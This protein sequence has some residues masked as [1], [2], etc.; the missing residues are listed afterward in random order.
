MK[1]SNLK[2]TA[3]RKGLAFMLILTLAG[4]AAGFYYGLQQIRT[5][6]V[7]V[8]NKVADAEASGAQIEQLRQLQQTLQQSDALIA[9]ADSIFATDASYQT[10]AITDLERYASVAGIDIA[11]TE[12]PT[13]AP[14]T[15][16]ARTV[17]VS[18]AQPLS[19]ERLLRFLEL[20]E[21]NLPKMQPT[22]ITV[23]RPDQPDGDAVV[24]SDI[25]I[26]ISTRQQ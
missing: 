19:Y 26:T 14:A 22:S 24:V 1:T 12:F 10:Q 6:A 9:K 17:T 13:D 11:S 8:S 20:V 18:L 25:T 3:L 2:A 16:N 23:S 4:T 7:E 15:P 21:G 5:Y